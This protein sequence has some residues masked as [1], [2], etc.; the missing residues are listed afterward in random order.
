MSCIPFTVQ[1]LDPETEEWSDLWHLHA[2]KVNKSGGGMATNA[3]ADQYRATLTFEVAWF[4]ALEAVRY[5]PQLY[6]IVYRGHTFKLA[7]YDDYM[8]RHL[9]VNLVGEAYG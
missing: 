7:D 1:I 6:R 3:G 9:T 4:S 2:R 5:K 8:E